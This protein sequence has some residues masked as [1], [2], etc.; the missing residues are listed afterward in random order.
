[1]IYVTEL[2]TTPQGHHAYRTLL[3]DTYAE[4]KELSPLLAKYIRVGEDL[5]SS[6][7]DQE[8][9]TEAKRKKLGL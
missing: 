7:K 6:R 8:E 1:M 4:F 3:Q 2:R 5:E 9:K